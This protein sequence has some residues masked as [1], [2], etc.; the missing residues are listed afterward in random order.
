MWAGYDH[1]HFI[2]EEAS[3][4]G[5][6]RRSHPKLEVEPRMECGSAARLERATEEECVSLSVYGKGGGGVESLSPLPHGPS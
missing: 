2:G 6:C 3:G 5:V 4:G 1:P